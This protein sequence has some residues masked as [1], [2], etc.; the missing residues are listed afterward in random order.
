VRQDLIE[1][2]TG[3]GTFIKEK[4]IANYISVGNAM[5]AQMTCYPKLADARFKRVS[6]YAQRLVLISTV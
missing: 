5:A 4:V 3:D 1:I 2:A 6:K